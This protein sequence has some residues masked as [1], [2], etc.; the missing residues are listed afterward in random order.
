MWLKLYP[1][2]S[3]VTGAEREISVC[4]IHSVCH[5]SYPRSTSPQFNARP[6]CP[7][8]GRQQ[9]V[10]VCVYVTMV[11]LRRVF[12]ALTH[13]FTAFHSYEVM[14]LCSCCFPSVKNCDHVVFPLWWN[15]MIWTLQPFCSL[16]F[17]K[18]WSISGLWRL[19]VN[20]H[21]DVITDTVC[22]KQYI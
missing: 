9:C 18:V 11:T 14:V 5:H 6:L 7:R 17:V 19:I 1:S 21:L 3:K 12:I 22:V 15:V 2:L 16:I 4:F 13:I 8:W 10:C 20:L